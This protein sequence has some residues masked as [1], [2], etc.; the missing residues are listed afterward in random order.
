MRL[1]SLNDHLEWKEVF[2]NLSTRVLSDEDKKFALKPEYASKIMDLKFPVP[3]EGFFF[4]DPTGE[5][6]GRIL[7]QG[8]VLDPEL[9]H[10]GL[11]CLSSQPKHQ[12][13]FIQ[14][15]PQVER[16]FH[17]YGIKKIVGPYL[18]TTFF[19]YR[20]RTDQLS[21]KYAWE[22]NQP[23]VDVEVFQK[24]G[25]NIHQTYFTNFIDGYGI[26]ET[27][28]TKEYEEAVK[29]G[30]RFREMTKDTIENDVKIIY[31]LSMKGFTDNY[32]FA[33]IPFELFQSIYV[34]SFQSV[35]LRT[36]CI[37]ED[38]QG[39]PIGF[40][41][42]FVMDDQI[43][44]KSVCVLPEYRGK[45]LLNAGIRYTMLRAMSLYPQVKKVA[46]ALI[47]EDNGPSRHVAN[48]TVDRQRHEYVLMSKDVE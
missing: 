9:G 7:L 22:P 14:L 40:N 29:L 21:E 47:H 3:S 26:F 35:D 48:L 41:F 1:I 44:I 20:L 15:W 42:T 5:F 10:W 24:L 33:P 39:N 6:F 4:E 30:F 32:L 43:V 16:W 45:G 11:F 2:C 13:M 18:Y 23:R 31:D 19:P 28:G 36:S 37:Q 27:K 25:F 46:T 8:S 12:D 38:P 17:D 34:P